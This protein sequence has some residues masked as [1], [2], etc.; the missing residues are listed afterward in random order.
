MRFIRLHIVLSLVCLGAA[1]AQESS[2]LESMLK[3]YQQLNY[4]RAEMYAGEILAAYDA[5]PLDV[6]T[7]VHT[8]LGIIKYT[9]NSQQE[10]REQFETAL[11]LTPELSLDPALVSPKIL[12][13]FDT[14]KADLTTSSGAGG[15]TVNV[16]YI[17]LQ[18]PRPAAAMRSIVV[19]GW[20][21]FYKGE[22]KKGILL[23]G[24]WAAT[25][26]GTLAA[27]LGRQQARDRYRAA[28]DPDDIAARYKTYNSRNK[29]RNGL[30]LAAA[31]VWVFSYFD[32]LVKP[33]Q[34]SDSNS[35]ASLALFPDTDFPYTRLSFSLIF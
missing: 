2:L 27:H 18:D 26:G 5:Y 23:T 30:A 22:S 24:L 8:T 11:S 17:V 33:V 3:A 25:A 19:P 28:R 21:H 20:G 29:L 16:R 9:Q 15:D 1:Q 34:I 4:D 13:F 35:T 31:G 6:L 14:L 12:S 32:V 10:A 7:Q